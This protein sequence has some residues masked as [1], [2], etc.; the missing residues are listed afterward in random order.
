MINPFRELDQGE[1]AMLKSSLQWWLKEINLNKSPEMATALEEI[2]AA[3]REE[4]AEERA[5]SQQH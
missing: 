1:V 4:Q 5:E 2:A 3:I